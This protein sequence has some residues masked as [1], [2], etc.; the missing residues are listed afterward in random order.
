MSS[1]AQPSAMQ[2][3]LNFEPGLVDRFA[4]LREFLAHRVQVQAKPAKSIAMDMD[5]SPSTLSRKLSPGDGDTQRFNVDDLERFIQSTGD[6]SA[7]EYLAAKYLE[8]DGARRLRMLSRAEQMLP[9]L[10][11][12]LQSIQEAR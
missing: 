9:E 11:R 10:A 12:L 4:S 6:T 8:D 5:L 1:R 7:I 2:L 3:T